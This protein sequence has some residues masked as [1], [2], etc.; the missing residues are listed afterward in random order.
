MGSVIDNIEKD[1]ALFKTGLPHRHLP[2]SKK[3]WGNANHSLCSYQGKLKPAI[4]HHLVQT[5]VPDKGTLF[6]PFCG[7]GTIP[8]EGALSGRR[9]YGMDI[10]PLAYYVASAKLHRHFPSLCTAYIEKIGKYISTHPVSKDYV[11]RHSSFGYNKT[12]G[13]YFHPETFKE[14]LAARLF[15]SLQP[16][17]EPEEMLVMSSLL[18]ILHG[19]RPY[20]LSRKSHPII[21]Y[22]PTGDFVYKN[23][24]EKLREKVDRALAPN[25]YP[26][27]FVEGK[28]FLQDTLLS[29]PEE[30]SQ[31]DAI[32]T[33]PPF[34]DSTRFYLAN[35]IRLWFTGWEHEDFKREPAKYLDE[36]QKNGLD[37]YT[38]IFEQAKSRLKP[39][40][41]LIL[42]LG[43]SRKCDMG[44]VLLG[45]AKKYFSH[46]DL[47]DESVVD[48][49]KFGIHDIGTVTSHEYLVMR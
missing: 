7:I 25:L 38:K 47:F 17:R 34:Y 5:F 48:C 35:W 20:A 23:L 40:G 22:A 13:E 9:A 21:P 29:W 2:Y 46:I 37:I 30:I 3:N 49:S 42:H 28:V 11:S 31:I 41:W 26:T 6:D 16:P 12:L 33:S 27:E 10:S 24:I 36:K 14:I 39:D 15:F 1:W 45:Y 19:N 8:F 32:I 43:K 44:Q 4:A 18:H